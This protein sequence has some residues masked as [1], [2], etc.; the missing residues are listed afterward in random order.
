MTNFVE[1]YPS[2]SPESTLSQWLHQAV[3]IQGLRF[4]L[5]V[6]GNNLY[7]LCEADPI[8]DRSALL[9]QL[10]PA[11]Q[12]TD[13]NALLPNDF[14]SLYQVQ[15]Y[16]GQAGKF[17][18]DWA[19]TIYLNQLDEHVAQLQHEQKITTTPSAVA[20]ES[21][22]PQAAS[23]SP[24]DSPVETT[25]LA[26][27]NR[28]LARQGNEMAIA[29]YL[30]ETLSNLGIAVRVSVK[31]IPCTIN[32][33]VYSTDII[34]TSSTSKRLWIAC[35]ASYK[36]DPSLVC[37]SVT[38]KLRDLEIEG[39]RDAVILFQVA[40]ETQPDWLLRVD[41]TPPDEMLRDWARWG[42]LEAVQRLLNQAIARFGSQISTATLK[43]SSLH[44]VCT[45]IANGAAETSQPPDRQQIQTE[46]LPLLDLLAPQ[47]IQTA[48]IYGQVPHQS[49]P[50]WVDWIELPAASH[51]ALADSPLTL[52]LQEDWSA[53]AFLLHR[54]LNPDLDQYL[55]TGGIRLQ[56]LPKQDLLHV[57]SESVLCPDQRHVSQTIVRF[58]KQLKLPDLAGVRIYGR[59]AGQK[60][61]MWNYGVDF[62]TRE[63]IVPEPA[64]EFAASDAYVNDLI[65]QADDAVIRPDL[66][67]ERVQTAWKTIQEKALYW[68]QHLL[69]RSQLFVPNHDRPSSPA[70]P[71]SSTQG[72]TLAI[73]WGLVGALVV[74]QANW[75]LEGILRRKSPT[76]ATEPT[77]T[78]PRT[79]PPASVVSSTTP[80]ETAEPSEFP[81][82]DVELPRSNST[83]ATAFESD[84]FTESPPGSVQRTAPTSAAKPDENT[85]NED[86]NDANTD[87]D[88]TNLPYTPQNPA[89]NLAL[90]QSLEAE[91][92]ALD[93]NSRQFND[94]LQL[95]YRVLEESGPPDV[96]IVG[97]SRA[98]RGVD[99]AALEQALANL[100]H[101]NVR[102]FNFGINGA[103]AQV[104][105]LL[106]RQLLT[107]EQLPDLIVWADGARAFNSN[108]VDVT[109]NGMIASSS[110]QELAQGRL[111]LPQVG[112]ATAETEPVTVAEGINVTLTDSYQALDRWLSQ[113]FAQVIRPHQER[114][115][116]KQLIQQQV[117]QMLPAAEPT[118]ITSELLASDGSL[119]LSKPTAT[120]PSQ[121]EFVDA[122]GFLSLGVQFNPATYYQKYAK[123]SGDYDRDYLDFQITGV[124]EQALQTVLQYT[125]Q[126]QIP[127]AFINLPMTDEYLDATRKGYEQQF[128]DQMIRLSLQQPGFSFH[129]LSE[130]W[131]TNY[132]Y[133]SDPSHLNRYGAYAVSQRIAQD[134]RIAWSNSVNADKEPL[135]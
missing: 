33:N 90:A 14:P 12:Q 35:Q 15:V 59:R 91:S 120:F 26:V 18:P 126:Q 25:V 73:V 24:S 31:T 7:L 37:E 105:D 10:L 101:D 61:P 78:Q 4:K 115:R 34:R 121:Y 27:S 11:L 5:Q 122:D 102:V 50:A 56:L 134:P 94:K 77:P 109:Y 54:L 21:T 1:K 81:F 32:S 69:M 8:P 100:G 41:L 58:L 44:L 66:T 67:P 133:F 22:N 123:V 131:L 72:Y 82:S 51:P 132:D 96:L 79:T 42:D 89:V 13:L 55:L 118:A 43:E 116:L 92:F 62:V 29:S 124:Q 129:D 119:A 19:F 103:T 98:L 108:A 97:S 99:P 113:R 6:R 38:Q 68:V 17:Q 3:G 125:Q 60:Q 49:A 111:Q 71:G 74:V 104:I 28:S 63:R 23:R 128:R 39:Y 53:I 64:P 93:F 107:P 135:D 112:G 95:Y 30:S 114:D 46:V 88:A 106:V 86:A 48:T 76:I 87:A 75:L 57:M 40:G 127:V 117:A 45:V 84:G 36:P 70:L 52:A 65:A 9:R 110:Y 2:S 20:Q 47:G 80:V 130:A 16:G 85:G 83:D